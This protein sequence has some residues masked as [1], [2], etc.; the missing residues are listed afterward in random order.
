MADPDAEASLYTQ[1][2]L[3]RDDTSILH[4]I[5]R[6]AR[7]AGYKPSDSTYLVNSLVKRGDVDA[8]DPMEAALRR[9]AVACKGAEPVTQESLSMILNCSEAVIRTR[10]STKGAKHRQEPLGGPSDVM[11]MVAIVA[12]RGCATIISIELEDG[13]FERALCDP[14]RSN[15]GGIPLHEPLASNAVATNPVA[16]PAGQRS[17]PAQ[18]QSPPESPEPKLA[19]KQPDLLDSDA[20]RNNLQC[21]AGG[22]RDVEDAPPYREAGAGPGRKRGPDDVDDMEQPASKPN[23]SSAPSVVPSSS[24][25]NIMAEIAGVK[26]A[27]AAA[28]ASGKGPELTQEAIDD[29]LAEFAHSLTSLSKFVPGHHVKLTWVPVPP[30]QQ[31]GMQQVADI[32]F[33]ALGRG[34]WVSRAFKDVVGAINIGMG[35]WYYGNL[36]VAKL[37]S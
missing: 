1:D 30:A 15:N 21:L 5:H 18:L 13:T 12:N 22:H 6:K 16:T 24:D 34:Q 33:A 9:Y 29:A 23:A 19:S 8:M 36:V 11:N 37:R 32:A 28:C 25:W 20:L 27:M 7:P 26:Q 4:L 14:S 17:S 3:L 10:R 35:V 31:T 2:G